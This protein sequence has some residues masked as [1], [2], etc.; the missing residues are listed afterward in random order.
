MDVVFLPCFH[1]FQYLVSSILLNPYFQD[2]STYDMFI[3]ELQYLLDS[4]TTPIIVSMF[5]M[6]LLFSNLL[7]KID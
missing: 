4:R 3:S 6:L 1:I 2:P 5:K 7:C